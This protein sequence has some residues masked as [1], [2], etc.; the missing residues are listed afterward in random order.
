MA[1]RICGHLEDVP[2]LEQSSLNLVADLGSRGHAGANSVS[3]ITTSAQ[4]GHRA[5]ID[6]RQG[7]EQG[8]ETGC[9]TRCKGWR[10][11]MRHR[12]RNRDTSVNKS[13]YLVA[14]RFPD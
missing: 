10:G 8:A 3:S 12:T 2:N 7:T 4:V 9:R 13:R 6:Q 11:I 1:I 14:A 5:Q